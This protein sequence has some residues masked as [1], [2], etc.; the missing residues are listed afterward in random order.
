MVV[1]LSPQNVDME[2]A[3]R[4]DGERVED[5]GDH[6]ARQISNFLSLETELCDTVGS[7]ADVDDCAGEGLVEGGISVT[8]AL[9]SADFPKGLFESSSEGN[10]AVLCGVVVVDPEIPLALEGEGHAAVLCEGRVHVVEEA[11]AGG[12]VDYLGIVCAGLAVEV[13]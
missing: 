1:V 6:L 13:Y 10:G 4:S 3:S 12:D 2:S 11:D 9:D 8:V 5:V 7:R